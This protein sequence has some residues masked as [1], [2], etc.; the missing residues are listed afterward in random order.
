MASKHFI[1]GA[2]KRKGALTRRVGG[3]PSTRIEKVEYLQRHGSPRER[4][5][6]SFYLNVLRPANKKR[7]KGAKGG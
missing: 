5:E 3:K 4:R 7:K 6:A 2:V 1:K